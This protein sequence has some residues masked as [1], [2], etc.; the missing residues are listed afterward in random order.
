VRALAG[1]PRAQARRLRVAHR[2]RYRR[3]HAGDV[4]SHVFEPFF[5]TKEQG[6][7]TGLGLATIYGIV[8]QSGGGIYVSTAEKQGTTFSIYLPRHC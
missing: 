6:K 1:F 4:R 2:D 3:R 5:T 8:K 7:G